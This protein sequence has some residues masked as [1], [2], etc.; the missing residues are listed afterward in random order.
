MTERVEIYLTKLEKERLY[1]LRPSPGEA[2]DFWKDVA[3]VR[4]LDYST[5]Y[6]LGSSCTALPIGHKKHWCFPLSL[7][8]EKGKSFSR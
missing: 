6:V 7:K 2:F 4:G 3:D 1:R 8:A 5:I